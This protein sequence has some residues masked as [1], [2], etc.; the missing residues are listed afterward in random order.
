MPRVDMTGRLSEA[1]HA[2]NGNRQDQ[3]TPRGRRTLNVRTPDAV[4]IVRR[5]KNRKQIRSRANAGTRRA[6]MVDM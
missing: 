4:G 2:N 1:G 3:R 6:N 5:D